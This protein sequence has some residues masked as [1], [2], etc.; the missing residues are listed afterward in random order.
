MMR[1]PHETKVL[2]SLIGGVISYGSFMCLK[3][4]NEVRWFNKRTRWPVK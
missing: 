1:I 3:K 2:L 4:G